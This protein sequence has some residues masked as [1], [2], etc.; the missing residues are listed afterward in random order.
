MKD[1]VR[2]LGG[3]LRRFLE[4][5]RLPAP[6]RKPAAGLG[7]ALGGGFARGLAHIGVLKV[8]EENNIPVRCLAGT[9]IGSI[10][11][12]AYA[13]G[14]SLEEMAATG[15]KIRWRDFGQWTFSRMGFASNQRLEV[16][17]KRFFRA[18]RFEDLK[19]P[20]AILASDLVRAR[21]VVFTS[22]ELTLA[23]RASCAYPGLF[24]PVNHNGRVLVDGMLVSGVPTHAVADLGATVVVAVS[25][26]N[27]TPPAMPKSVV[28]VLGRSFSIAQQTA[29]PLWRKHA[30]IVIEPEV[31]E[32]SWDDF[33]RADELIAAGERAMRAALP[34]LRRLLKVPA[35]ELVAAK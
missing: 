5:L 6:R 1:R 9:S 2:S 35:G 25:L 3:G 27:L 8:L 30:D 22:G 19:L 26:N 21:A 18:T 14:V 29:E 13:S 7:L 17:V 15:K 4:R 23:V 32:Y 31:G 24:L 10:I 12:G 34:K 16:L 11:A 20:L 28:E 33:A